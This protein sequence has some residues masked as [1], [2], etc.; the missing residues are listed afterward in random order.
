MKKLI[1]W[2]IILGGGGYFG[3]KWYLH[4]RVSSDLDDMLLM[5][6]PFAKVDYRGVR[7]VR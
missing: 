4:Y 2:A 1:V 5:V 7:P 3:A 6:S